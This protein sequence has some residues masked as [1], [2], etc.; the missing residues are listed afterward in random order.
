LPNG[1]GY[2]VNGLYD[3]V[4]TKFGQANYEVQPSKNYGN[5][6]QYWSG[7]DLNF[8]VR[9]TSGLMFQ[10]GTST[11]QTVQDFCELSTALP[12]SNLPVVSTG[13]GISIPGRVILNNPAGSTPVGPTPTQYCHITSG[14]LTQFRGVG[15]YQIPKIDVELSATYQSKPGQQLGANYAVPSTVVAQSLGRPLAG[16]VANVTVNMIQPGTFYGD[17]I[18]QVDFRVAKVF[19]F[20][21]TKARA[22]VDFYNLLNSAPILTYN[23][24]YSPTSTTWLTPTSVLAARVA[25]IGF[26]FEF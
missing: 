23:Q 24:T 9:P 6:S 26:T 17:R 19:R 8:S 20:G 2:P 25:K 1:G 12:E 21:A 4:P 10:G 18:N 11:G 14:F 22:Q 16:S 15:S 13:I 5:D 7:I 3:I